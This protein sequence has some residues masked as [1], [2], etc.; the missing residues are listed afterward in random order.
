MCLYHCRLL[1]CFDHTYL[2]TQAG[3]DSVTINSSGGG[4]APEGTAVL[5]T[6]EG[7]GT[8]FLREDG[9]G[10]CS[11]QAA[12]GGAVSMSAY[13]TIDSDGATF[14]KDHTYLATQA[15]MVYVTDDM[16][17]LEEMTL[18][19]GLTNDPVGA[20]LA[21]ITHEM[22]DA[23]RKRRTISVHVAEGEYFELAMPGGNPNNYYWKGFGTLSAPVDQEA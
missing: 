7:G 17:S 15:G 19:V 9:D 6:G 14:L 13:S 11:W 1:R 21:I 4:G 5:S 22:G 18:Y 8:K 23:G 12:A 10:T 16:A 3:T 2:A 20:G